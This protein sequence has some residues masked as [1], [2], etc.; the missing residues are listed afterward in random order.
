MK[1]FLGM[2]LLGGNFVRAMTG[3]GEEVQVWNRTYA[4]ALELEKAGAKVFKDVADAVRDASIVH[5]TLKDDGA[6]NETLS[7]AASGLKA[8]A[9]IIDHSTTSV[10]GAIERTREWKERGYLYQHAPVFM[11]PPN[12][13]ES[14]G[15]MLISGDQTLIMELEPHLSKMTGCLL[16]FG[17]ET[18][19][20]AAMKL[21]GSA[22]PG[23]FYRGYCRHDLIVKGTKSSRKR[24]EQTI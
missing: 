9:V 18:G 12:A 4:K 23:H 10:E 6:V 5:L 20:A 11:G 24:Y 14:T 17:E 21:I 1:A 22:F 19:R 2:G 3:K 15:Y 16:N 7:A 13:L 8:G